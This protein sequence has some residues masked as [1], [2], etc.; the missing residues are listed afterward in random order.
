MMAKEAHTPGPWSYRPD[1]YDDWGIVRAPVTEQGRFRGGIICQA[2]NLE[3]LD[4]LTFAKHREAGTDPW[5]AN[6]RLIAAAPELLEALKAFSCLEVPR[7]PDGNA[8][9]FSIPFKRIEAARSAVSKALGE[10]A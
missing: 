6:A 2:K 4:E 9:F 8:G 1:E 5:E 3:A 10:S 7:N